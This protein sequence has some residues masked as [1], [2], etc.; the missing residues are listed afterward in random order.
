MRWA[1]YGVLFF[2]L[3]DSSLYML[4]FTFYTVNIVKG[5]VILVAALLDVLRNRVRLGWVPAGRAVAA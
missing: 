5:I 1:F 2:V 4:N 3:L